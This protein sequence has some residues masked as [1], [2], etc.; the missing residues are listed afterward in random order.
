MFIRWYLGS[1]ILIIGGRHSDRAASL[2]NPG[3]PC[4]G[5]SMAH[6]HVHLV[7]EIP[8]LSKEEKKEKRSSKLQTRK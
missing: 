7:M 5:D 6:H 8:M 3:P 2:R 1:N 4:Q